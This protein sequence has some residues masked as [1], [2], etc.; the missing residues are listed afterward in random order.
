[1]KTA[2]G[3]LHHNNWDEKP[4][5]EAAPQKSTMAI[6]DVVFE[7]D[8]EARAVTRFLMQ[9]PDDKTCHYS[10]YLVVEG[11]LDGKA[12]GFIIFELGTWSDGVARSTWEIVENSG[13]GGLA[14]IIGKGRYAAQHNKTVHYEL[15][16][17]LK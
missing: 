6:I 7:G 11:K 4:Y 2:K 17:D 13:T 3:V 8:I 16:Y 10:G 12:G 9:Y 5:H 1:M 15:S 14:G